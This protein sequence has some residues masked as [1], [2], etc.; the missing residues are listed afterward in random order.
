MSL[1]GKVGSAFRWTA[2]AKLGAQLISWVGTL[3]VMRLL[4]PSDYGLAAICSA[5][6][7]IV[8]MIAEF[9]FGSALVQ[10]RTLTRDQ[11]RSVFGAAL[12][13]A[14]AS[15]GVVCALAPLLAT[16]FRA[17]EAELLIQVASVNLLLYALTTVPDAMLRREMQFK[18]ASIVELAAGVATTVATVVMAKTGC[19]VWALVLG[20]VGGSVLRIVLLHAILPER[21][22]P[23]FRIGE[24]RSLVKFG[25]SVALARIASYVFGQADVLLA[26]RI[27]SKTALGEYSVAM[28]LAMLPLSRVMGIITQVAFPAI[29]QLY[30][31]K[32]DIRPELLSG[33]RLA[34]YVV[35]PAL[36]GIGS[37]A[38]WFVRV[39][40]GPQWDDAAL[41]LQI[42]CAVLPLRLIGTL[43]ATAVQGVGRPDIDLRNSLTGVLVMPPCFLVGG[44]FGT[45]GLACGWLV[46]LPLLMAINLRRAQPVLRISILDALKEI[47]RPLAC[48]AVMFAA[49]RLVAAALQDSANTAWGLGLLI[50][51]GAVVYAAGVWMIDRA[52]LAVL[53]GVLRP[54]R[55]RPAVPS[56]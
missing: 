53:W 36:W 47:A 10:S 23:S 39:A 18:G 48:S 41:P 37:I 27:L 1:G 35:I 34:A 55:M 45:T 15:M 42:V 9:G 13:F 19:G 14:L 16:F 54:G 5:V 26:G 40:L 32:Q 33:L 29:A 8:S 21:V 31:D 22:W 28:H 43:T 38:P 6:L 52:A 4:V 46:G 20:S 24:A 25:R 50:I 7:S 49:V 56:A 17:P 3:F 12:L 30:R 2:A 44:M 51:V 11:I